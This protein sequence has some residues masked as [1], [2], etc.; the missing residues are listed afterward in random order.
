MDTDGNGQGQGE[1]EGHDHDAA[2]VALRDLRTTI[3]AMRDVTV[4][5][6][7]GEGLSS[8]TSDTTTTSSLCSL[9]L[10]AETLLVQLGMSLKSLHLEKEG[11]LRDVSVARDLLHAEN[12]QLFAHKYILNHF[13]K[14]IQSSLKRKTKYT[15][16]E[17]D[18]LESQQDNKGVETSGLVL[19]RD[20]V[21]GAGEVVKVDERYEMYKSRLLREKRQRKELKETFGQVSVKK[22]SEQDVLDANVTFERSLA[23][24]VATQMEGVRRMQNLFEDSKYRKGFVRSS[25]VE[26]L[27]LPLHLLVA[28]ASFLARKDK[29]VSVSI[30]GTTSDLEEY[31]DFAEKVETEK[32]FLLHPVAVNVCFSSSGEAGEGEAGEAGEAGDGAGEVALKFYFHPGLN[33]VFVE[34]Q[35]TVVDAL[36]KIHKEDKGEKLEK[37]LEAAAA[38]VTGEAG[39]GKGKSSLPH[40]LSAEKVEMMRKFSWAQ[41]MCGLTTQQ[42][43][44]DSQNVLSSV[45]E[46]SKQ[47]EFHVLA[48]GLLE[49]KSQ[50]H[51]PDE[52]TN[53]ET[54]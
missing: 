19:E 53:K 31:C 10:K 23:K 30:D 32:D 47:R 51:R 2:W 3:H 40:Y 22:E 25:L 27:P 38:E 28:Q 52:E 44:S 46:A 43:N 33:A 17:L 7:G 42:N 8:N 29:R 54:S 49:D 18:L 11:V 37:C 5:F 50:P 39:E 36:R 12:K 6:E 41:R 35:K 21:H 14:R 48:Q 45:R 15:D 24:E 20:L 4:S 13:D 34:A 9:R 16:E 26:Y 1:G